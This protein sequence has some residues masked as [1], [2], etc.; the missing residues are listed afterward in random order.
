MVLVAV[1]LSELC[2][3]ILD[4]KITSDIWE[5]FI[6]W[7]LGEV[8]SGP[9]VFHYFARIWVLIYGIILIGCSRVPLISMAEEFA[10]LSRNMQ[11][12]GRL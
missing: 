12:S 1:K 10:L 9:R 5:G 6:K 8:G 3:S 4:K 11:N 7:R 2:Y